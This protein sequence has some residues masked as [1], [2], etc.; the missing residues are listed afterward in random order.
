MFELILELTTVQQ[1]FIVALCI[2]GYTMSEKIIVLVF[3]NYKQYTLRKKISLF[4]LI[5]MFSVFIIQTLF[6]AGATDWNGWFARGIYYPENLSELFLLCLP[7]Y[8]LLLFAIEGILG[9][10]YLLLSARA[11]KPRL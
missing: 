5:E 7:F 2:L 4:L 6:F 8:I 1:M 10:L 11:I 3:K 9:G